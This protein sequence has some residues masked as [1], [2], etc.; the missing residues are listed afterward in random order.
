MMERNNDIISQI[1]FVFQRNHRFNQLW[2]TFPTIPQEKNEKKQSLSSFILDV[3]T[4]KRIREDIKI[5]K[6]NLTAFFFGWKISPRWLYGE[7]F[8][9]SVYWLLWGYYSAPQISQW[10]VGF[11]AFM[12]TNFS[13]WRTNFGVNY[14]VVVWILTAMSQTAFVY[15]IVRSSIFDDWMGSL[16]IY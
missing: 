14:A 12:G 1:W 2:S 15:L 13:D 16:N 11:F 9:W 7:A 6:K 10:A 4:R 3:K 8:W 5:R